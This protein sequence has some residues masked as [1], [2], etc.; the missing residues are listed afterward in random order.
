MKNFVK[1]VVAIMFLATAC[2]NANQKT[3]AQAE[4]KLPEGAI[5]MRYERHLYFDVMLRDS[6]PARMFL[7]REVAIY[8]WTLH[9]TQQH[10]AR[11]TTS[12]ERCFRVPGMVFS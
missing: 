2:S 3:V 5:E 8:C 7:I 11:T 1:L 12:A 10:L 4:P 9:F 6:I